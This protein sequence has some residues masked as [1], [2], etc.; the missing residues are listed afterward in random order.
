MKTADSNLDARE[1][2][3]VLSCLDEIIDTSVLLE[4]HGDK[5]T[6]RESKLKQVYVFIGAYT[7]NNT[8]DV[9]T[10]VQLEVKEYV[11]DNNQLYLAVAIKKSEVNETSSDKADSA[12]ISDNISITDLIK[13]INPEAVDFLKYIP[14]NF[15]NEAQL[16]GKKNGIERDIKK[17]PNSPYKEQKTLSVIQSAENSGGYKKRCLRQIA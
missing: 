2:L 16:K 14:D 5:K 9:I 10:P 6:S 17:Y 15:L 4:K 12:S 11:D 3:D 13:K 7:G 8:K 1:Y